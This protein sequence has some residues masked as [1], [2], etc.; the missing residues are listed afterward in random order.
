MKTLTALLRPDGTTGPLAYLLTGS[1]LLGLKHGLDWLLAGLFGQPWSPFA[2]FVLPGQ[3]LGLL[4][5]NLSERWFLGTVLALSVPFIAVGVLLTLRR[6]NDARL[7]GLLT[8]LFFVPVVNL[9][10]FLLLAVLPG[11]PAPGPVP[12]EEAREAPPEQ[13]Q[14]AGT[15]GDPETYRRLARGYGDQRWRRLRDT[16]R[17]VTQASHTAEAAIALLLTVPA[18]IAFVGLSTLVLHNYG[19]G[20]FVGTPFGF[21]LATAALFGLSRPQPLGA[22][23]GVVMLGTTIAGFAILLFALE[24]AICLLMAAPLGYALALLGGLVGYVLQS[25]P[26]LSANNVTYLLLLGLTL[27][28]LLAA[29]AR[30]PAEPDVLEVVSAVDIDAPPEVVWRQVIAFPELPEPDEWL[31]L[32]GVAYPVRAEID[33][34]GPGAVR[35]CVFSTGAFVEPIDVWE[36]PRLLAFRVLEQP[37]PMTEWSPYAI[38]PPHL[39]HYLVS[40]RGQFRL[41]ALPDGRTRLEGTTWYT[42]RMWPAAYWRSWS[43]AI[44]HRIHLRVLRH[45][46]TLAEAE[47]RQASRRVDPAG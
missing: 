15:A 19:W 43:D 1:V 17:Q 42:N 3:T 40:R 5:L 6:L 24:G 28:A 9:L 33:G 29:E 20:L 21:G 44:I 18:A 23:L 46:R 32:C 47:A 25:R 27:P 4:S 11:R 7:P 14:G 36:E 38:H 26:W 39:D 41:I 34:R 31:F 22:C 13:V 16:H 10:F 2:Y 37:E 8:L 45:I 35:R 12:A 30:T